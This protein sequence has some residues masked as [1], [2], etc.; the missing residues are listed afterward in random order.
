MSLDV[1]SK[2]TIQKRR[3]INKTRAVRGGGCVGA[4]GT[5]NR[6]VKGE[7]V[8]GRQQGCLPGEDDVKAG[9]QRIGGS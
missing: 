7:V 8:A 5:Q 6:D 2:L 1:Q 4:V 3:Q 9:S